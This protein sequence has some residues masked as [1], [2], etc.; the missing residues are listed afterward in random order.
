MIKF[1]QNHGLERERGSSVVVRVSGTNL[2]RI[3]EVQCVVFGSISDITVTSMSLSVSKVQIQI[4][5]ILLVRKCLHLCC[6][7]VCLIQ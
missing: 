2:S 1:I 7:T 4:G 6:N 3:F 5:L